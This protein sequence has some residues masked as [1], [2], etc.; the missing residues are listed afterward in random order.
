VTGTIVATTARQNALSVSVGAG[1][2]GSV[3]SSRNGT[4]PD[5]G[6]GAVRSSVTGSPHVQ[7]HDGTQLLTLGHDLRQ[8]LGLVDAAL[9][10]GAADAV[11]RPGV[12]GVLLQKSFR[13]SVVDRP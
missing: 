4:A 8:A 9:V 1:S 12:H 7:V 6:S 11:H 3:R 2:P 13:C 10:R 5:T